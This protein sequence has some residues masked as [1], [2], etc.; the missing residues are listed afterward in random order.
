[1][2]VIPIASRHADT[3]AAIVAWLHANRDSLVY[4]LGDGQ[5]AARMVTLEE[6]GQYDRLGKCVVAILDGGALGSVVRMLCG[7]CGEDDCSGCGGFTT[8]LVLPRRIENLVG[9]RR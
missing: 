6:R 3:K 9:V 5:P 4:D 7:C 2:T 8:E 1:M